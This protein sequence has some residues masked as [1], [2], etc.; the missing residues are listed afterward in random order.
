[1]IRNTERYSF[2]IYYS[3]CA[4]FYQRYLPTPQIGLGG[5]HCKKLEYFRKNIQFF[6]VGTPKAYLEV[7]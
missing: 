5:T 2:E 1:M 4:D 7:Q 3:G 6:A